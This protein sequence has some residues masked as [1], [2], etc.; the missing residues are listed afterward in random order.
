MTEQGQSEKGEIIAQF[1]RLCLQARWNPTALEAA[2]DLATRGGFDW[3]AMR[4]AL[5]ADLWRES[6]WLTFYHIERDTLISSLFHVSQ[7][8]GKNVAC[9]ANAPLRRD[10]GYLLKKS[11]ETYSLVHDA[12]SWRFSACWAINSANEGMP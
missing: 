6:P 9:Q 1:L 5:L 2:R 8:V 12:P 4:R 11:G 10:S 3:Q 7:L